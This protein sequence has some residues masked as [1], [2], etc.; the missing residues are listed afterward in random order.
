MSCKNEFTV[1]SLGKFGSTAGD[2]ASVVLADAFF[3]PVPGVPDSAAFCCAAH[4]IEIAISTI[5]KSL[6][7]RCMSS[8]QDALNLP[9]RK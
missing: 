6:A 5:G 4:S 1:S 3:V 7:Q 9:A 2:E 8:F